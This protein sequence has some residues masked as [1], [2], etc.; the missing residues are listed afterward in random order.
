MK[1]VLHVDTSIWTSQRLTNMLL[2][3]ILGFH[4]LW[5]LVAATGGVVMHRNLSKVKSLTADNVE[6][7]VQD[8]VVVSQNGMRASERALPM[9]Q[10]IADMIHTAHEFVVP[11]APDPR[12]DAVSADGG[13]G[14]T[15]G[16][17]PVHARA[18]MVPRSAK[19]HGAFGGLGDLDFSGL[20]E[21]AN[22]F[23]MDSIKEAAF[24]VRDIPW[25]EEIIPL[26]KRALDNAESMENIIVA[27]T[28]SLATAKFRDGGDI[29]TPS[30]PASA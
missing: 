1:P 5:T 26:A 2:A 19:P 21:K 11:T 6:I 17:A 16:T 8:A 7:M 18:R 15:S 20:V 30:A 4:V 9:M 13:G 29:P 28:T 25:T 22:N 14:Y 10:E 23:N 3:C 24:A 27:I 12:A